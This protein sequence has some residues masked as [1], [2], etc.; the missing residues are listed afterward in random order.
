MQ[1]SLISKRLDV[2][3][4]SEGELTESSIGAGAAIDRSSLANQAYRHLKGILMRGDLEPGRR[5]ILRDVAHQLGISVTPIREALLQLVAEKALTFGD[6]G[7]IG[8][9][10]LAV[11]E[12]EELWRIRLLLEGE[13]AEI[14]A[15]KA[16]RR[17]VDALQ[18]AQDGMAQAKQD[19]RL[20]D[21]LKCNIDFHFA[22]Y[23]AAELPLMLELIEGI[24]ARSAPYVHF[25]QHHHVDKR[26]AAAKQGP[27]VH[28]TIIRAVAARD[29]LKARRALE[30]DLL[31][32]RAGVVRLLGPDVE[33]ASL[34]HVSKAKARVGRVRR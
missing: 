19:R 34:D 29:G 12:C 30:R 1:S 15:G 31:E 16:T 23:R 33:T 20:S 4:M 24:W 11:D 21:A 13:C 32:I 18:R 28:N 26:T 25:F 6:N 9:P 27:H 5:L 3:T 8:V 14:A 22:L 7:A 17:T 2:V 10:E